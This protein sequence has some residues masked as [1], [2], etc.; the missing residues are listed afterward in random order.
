[1]VQNI[2]AVAKEI[3]NFFEGRMHQFAHELPKPTHGIYTLLKGLHNQ[4]HVIF[5]SS[6]L[7]FG[8]Q[9]QVAKILHVSQKCRACPHKKISN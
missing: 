4:S 9:K 5:Y 2:L 1:M 3:P 6:I 7:C 8:S